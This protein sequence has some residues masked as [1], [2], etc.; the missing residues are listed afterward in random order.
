M[1]KSIIKSL[2]EKY[3]ENFHKINANDPDQHETIHPESTNYLKQGCVAALL[4]GIGDY[5]SD[6]GLPVLP[7]A[8]NEAALDTVF[9]SHLSEVKKAIAKYANDTE[10]K[11]GRYLLKT[12][13]RV[14]DTI[15]EVIG[16]NPK[17]IQSAF[18][19]QADEILN[20]LPA[21]MGISEILNHTGIDDRTHKMNGIL[22][23]FTKM[24]G[25]FLDPDSPGD[26]KAS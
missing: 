5:T 9:K 1:A 17:T 14:K 19:A 18:H 13:G 15:H 6:P 7:S 11:V 24:I 26:N 12:Y 21:S 2:Q 20:Y 3:G 16:D 23:S 22:S 4:A 8:D 10:E 25:K